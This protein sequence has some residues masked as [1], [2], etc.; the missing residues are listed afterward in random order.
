MHEY[1]NRPSLVLL[2]VIT[3]YT[4]IIASL[5][6]IPWLQE[7]AI[8]IVALASLAYLDPRVGR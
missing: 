8:L 4:A 3:G 7:A 1:P 6:Y 5:T 2:T